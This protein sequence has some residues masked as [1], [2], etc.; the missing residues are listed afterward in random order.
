MDI[1]SLTIYCSSS[2]LLEQKYY[3]L[4]NKIGELLGNKKISIIY[5]GG[6]VG[7]MGKISQSAM[8]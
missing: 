7:M 3:D 4:S 8:S 2:N 6:K 5:G 1:K